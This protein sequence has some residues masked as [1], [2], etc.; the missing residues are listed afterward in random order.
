MFTSDICSG[1]VKRIY[2]L[3]AVIYMVIYHTFVVSNRKYNFAEIKENYINLL[4]FMYD[5]KNIWG[6]FPTMRTVLIT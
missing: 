4:E 1:A 3:I 2:M 6:K 5:K